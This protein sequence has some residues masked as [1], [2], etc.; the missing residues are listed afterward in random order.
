MET[1]DDPSLRLTALLKL[2]GYTNEEIARSLDCVVGT[3]ERKLARIRHK[4]SN[5]VE[6]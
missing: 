2:Q 5:E 6:Q 3:V 1:L 4:W